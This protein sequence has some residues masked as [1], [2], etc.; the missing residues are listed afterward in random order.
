MATID[1]VVEARDRWLALDPSARAAEGADRVSVAAEAVGM[2]VA[3]L[4]AWDYPV[5]PMLEPCPDVDGAVAELEEAGPRV[6]PALVEIWRRIGAIRLVDL[7]RYR[8]MAFW[9][10]RLG[11]ELAD[12]ACDGVVV[13]GPSSEDWLGYALDTLYELSEY[14]EEPAFVLS[15]DDLH[16]DNTSGGGPYLV[17]P[18]EADPWMAP[19]Q[20]FGWGGRSRPRSAPEGSRPDLVSYLR[21]AVLECGGFPGY[22]GATAFEPHRLELTEGLPVF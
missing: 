22:S 15:P 11:P 10:D 16:K 8:H 1:A 18:D 19:L 5:D 17:L 14:G 4:A 21:T 12:L 13:E 20:D 7:D 2:L 9:D 3:R 6:P